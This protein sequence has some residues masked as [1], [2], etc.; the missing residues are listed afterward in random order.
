MRAKKP[1]SVNSQTIEG[2]PAER[3][4]ARF[5]AEKANLRRRYCTIFKFWRTCRF[6][7]CRKMR[8]CMG[9]AKA[10][11]KR[12]EASVSHNM[13]WDA[14]QHILAAT[15]ESAGPPERSA[16]ECPPRELYR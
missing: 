5:N 13:Q 11:L 6:K 9:D 16:R 1:V 8:T 10:C 7:P 4:R 2:I 15:P 12:G 3:Y 14:R